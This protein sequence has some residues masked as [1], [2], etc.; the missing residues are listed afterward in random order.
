MFENEVGDSGT[1]HLQGCFQLKAKKRMQPVIEA[2]MVHHAPHLE[3]MKAGIKEAALY[4][5]KDSARGV[6][7]CVV[8]EHGTMLIAG[9]RTDLTKAL[10]AFPTLD[11]L[12]DGEPEMYC[13]FRNGLRDIYAKRSTSIEKPVPRVY[14]FYGETGSGKSRQAHAML[15]DCVD[16]SW[17]APLNLDWFDGY[18]GQGAVLF[19]DFRKEYTRTKYGFSGL[20]RLLDRYPLNVNVRGAAPVPWVPRT[21]IITCNKSPGDCFSWTDNAGDTHEREDIEQLI[22]RITEVRHFSVHRDFE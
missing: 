11:E 19:D 8:H 1:P 21:I 13:R 7:G 20:L 16:G 9:G 12:M 6:E 18:C 2:M 15:A 3:I 14:W 5:K 17:V 4:C 10:E 22:R